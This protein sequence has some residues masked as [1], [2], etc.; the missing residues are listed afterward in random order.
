VS[1]EG[2]RRA[3]PAGAVRF[4]CVVDGRRLEVARWGRSENGDRAIVMLHEG[5]G[6][7]ALWK[8]V[9]HLI[10]E[11]TGHDVIAY[12]RYGYGHSDRLA[13]PRDVGY[14]HHE[15]LSVLPTLL[16]ELG[17][18]QPILLGHSDGA[19]IALI[20]AGSYPG[21]TS[22]L[23]LEAPHVFV[24]PLSIRSIARAK[25]AFETSDLEE[26][27]ARYHDDPRATFRGWN[28][29]W[30]DP[31]FFTWNIEPYVGKVDV[32]VLLVQ[33]EDDEY[34]TQAQLDAIRSRIPAE[35][36]VLERCGHSPHRDRPSEALDAIAAFIR[37]LPKPA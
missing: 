20:Y 37:A 35:T 4:D 7:I 12:S 27:L 29:I 25:A 21:S 23:I 8:D 16:T 9:P 13:E 19:S 22:A 33:G 14:M 28:D 15:A 10:A 36:V 17:L 2:T 3:A 1:V 32:P 30:L 31:R 34:G 11:R 6:S 5:L 26:K 18:S 24:E